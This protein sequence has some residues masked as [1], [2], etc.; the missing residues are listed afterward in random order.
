MT[1]RFSMRLNAEQRQHLEEIARARD[2]TIS[3]AVRSLID[4]A[5]KAD[6]LERRLEAVRQIT[7]VE[8]EVPDDP[9][10]LARQ[11]ESRYDSDGLP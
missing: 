3:D 7:S 11:S 9:Q 10:D 6:Q 5:W 4:D 2:V 1:A 8:I